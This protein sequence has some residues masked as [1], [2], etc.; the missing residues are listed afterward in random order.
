M[1]IMGSR[2]LLAPLRGF[3]VFVPINLRAYARSYMLPPLRG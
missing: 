3:D 1:N 2:K